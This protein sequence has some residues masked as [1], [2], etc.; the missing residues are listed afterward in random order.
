MTDKKNLRPLIENYKPEKK[1]K[2]IKYDVVPNKTTVGYGTGGHA[3]VLRIPWK[4]YVDIAESFWASTSR[5]Q[6]FLRDYVPNLKGTTSAK[7]QKIM[8]MFKEVKF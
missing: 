2:V 7:Q 6:N 4:K 3:I 5:Y 8:S 1:I